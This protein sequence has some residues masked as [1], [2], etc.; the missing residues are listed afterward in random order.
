MLV[1]NTC[2]D[3]FDGLFQKLDVGDARFVFRKIS[4]K[5]PQLRQVSDHYKDM[6]RTEL[7]KHVG[8]MIGEAIE[9]GGVRRGNPVN[10]IDRFNVYVL[11]GPVTWVLSPTGQFRSVR[12]NR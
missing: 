5:E 8:D 6:S 12:R 1:H 9:R 10:D 7:A 3:P 4:G 2:K 11:V